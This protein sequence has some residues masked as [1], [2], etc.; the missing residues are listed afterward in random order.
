LSFACEAQEL[1][2]RGR[3]IED[4]L[5]IG[6]PVRYTLALE[7]PR[8]IDIVFPDSLFDF[9]PFELDHKEYITTRTEAGISYDSA[10]Y[11]LTSFEI[12]T[13]QILSLPVF[14]LTQNDSLLLRVAPDTIYLQQMVTEIPDSVA[15]EAMPL[16]ENTD[17]LRVDYEFN[18]PYFLIGLTLFLIIAAGIIIFYGHS[19]RNRYKAWKLKKQHEKFIVEFTALI[20]R[21]SD[22]IQQHAEEVIIYWKSYLEKLEPFPYRTLTTRELLTK[23]HAPELAEAMNA[24]DQ[25]IYSPKVSTLPRDS[26][27]EL[28]TFAENRYKLKLERLQNG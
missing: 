23:E 15:L 2:P 24:I 5:K 14:R 3:F 13:A 10:I 22:S 18:Y 20:N 26:Y 6:Q 8:E 25:A 27:G 17:Y 9:S 12:D 19:I 7:Y 21:P 16:R 11:F 1:I 28:R 4:S